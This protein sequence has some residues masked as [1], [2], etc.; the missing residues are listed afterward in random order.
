MPSKAKFKK[1]VSKPALKN[2]DSQV[3]KPLPSDKII[4][5]NKIVQ[6]AQQTMIKS[7]YNNYLNFIDTAKNSGFLHGIMDNK[8]DPVATNKLSEKIISD[9]CFYILG[10]IEHSPSLIM[11]QEAVYNILLRDKHCNGIQFLSIIDNT[12]TEYIRVEEIKFK[13]I[14]SVNMNVFLL[15]DVWKLLNEKLKKIN[16]LFRSYLNKEENMIDA[17]LYLGIRS[18]DQIIMSMVNKSDK[19]MIM[20]VLEDLEKNIPI[21]QFYVFYDIINIYETIIKTKNSNKIQLLTKFYKWDPKNYELK[22]IHFIMT[23]KSL[24]ERYVK[25]MHDSLMELPYIEKVD[26]ISAQKIRTM[27]HHVYRLIPLSYYFSDRNLFYIYWIKYLEQR[28]LEQRKIMFSTELTIID[29]FASQFGWNPSIDTMKKMV[30][31]IH[32]SR[33]FNGVYYNCTL[34][35]TSKKYESLKDKKINFEL[36]SPNTIKKHVWTNLNDLTDE[37][38]QITLPLELDLLSATYQLFYRRANENDKIKLIP[39]YGFAII[40]YVGKDDITYYLYV[41][42]L[43]L[44]VIMQFNDNKKL[45]IDDIVKNTNM[46]K[47]VVNNILNGLYRGKILIKNNHGNE[48]I[49]KPNKEYYH[50]G[51]NVSLTEYYNPLI[52]NEPSDEKNEVVMNGEDNNINYDER[53]KNMAFETAITVLLKK[54]KTM[55]KDKILNKIKRD[56]PFKFNPTIDYKLFNLALEKLEKN[57]FIKKMTIDDETIYKYLS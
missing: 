16:S 11:V 35:I 37:K 45:T 36:I 44:I 10:L 2:A 31:D 42:T 9:A 57:K 53:E 14:N 47:G 25:F 21:S 29:K 8:Y 12:I 51:S 54:N 52:T 5:T 13:N 43:Q 15:N 18:F 24:I 7:S 32:D 38:S 56:L 50:N 41:N 55:D 3:D 49:F 20:Q 33:I 1:G 46:T 6:L 23:N 19:L 40:E 27:F 39:N 26:D 17:I 4:D 28:L 34:K 30:T 22:F 48:P